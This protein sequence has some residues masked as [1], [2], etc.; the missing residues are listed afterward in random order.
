MKPPPYLTVQQ[1][2]AQVGLSE[3]R[4]RFLIGAGTL[5]AVKIGWAWLIL[6]ADLAKLKVYGR[7]GHPKAE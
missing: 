3:Q 2:A 5:P 4:I 1:A 7:P 6:P